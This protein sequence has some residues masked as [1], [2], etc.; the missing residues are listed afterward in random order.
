M[1]DEDK[2]KVE[3]VKEI[4]LLREDRKKGVFK[5]ITEHKP[6]EEALEEISQNRG[7]LYDTEVVDAC[8]RLFKESDFKFE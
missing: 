5:N 1:K 2:T 4:K 6:A 8:L 7:I 3:L